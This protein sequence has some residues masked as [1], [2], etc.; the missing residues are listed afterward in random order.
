LYG[1]SSGVP[2]FDKL[3]KEIQMKTLQKG[4]TLIELMIVVA[5]IGIL[6]AI[7]IPQYQDYIAKTQASRVYG[8][9]NSVRTTVELCI[10]EGRTTLG[11]LDTQCDPGYTASNLVV[12]T[13]ASGIRTAPTGTGFPQVALVSGG[14][15]TIT[16]TFGNKAS[17]IL[18]TKKITLD[19]D[20]D[21][22]W[23]CKTDIAQAKHR[24]GSCS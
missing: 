16:S 2:L 12:G 10:L 21:G 13:D 15:G 6:A 1:G 18:A 20:A 24:P 5:I 14:T 8:E 23:V 4:F 3:L 17:S 9:A 22:T 7:A 19:R 11:S